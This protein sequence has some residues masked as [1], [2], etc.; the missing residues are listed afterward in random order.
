MIYL[1]DG[2]SLTQWK[3]N[4]W[5]PRLRRKNQGEIDMIW[6]LLKLCWNCIG[7]LRHFESNFLK[8]VKETPNIHMPVAGDK[9][10]GTNWLEKS[11]WGRQLKE[12][13]RWWSRN[14]YSIKKRCGLRMRHWYL[15]C[16]TFWNLKCR[17][18]L[19]LHSHRLLVLNRVFYILWNH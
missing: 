1:W 18:G 15:F 12:R 16:N 7:V 14:F 5:K 3:F 10:N 13:R 11:S 17:D 6:A 4:K 8:N 19:C 9:L 2:V